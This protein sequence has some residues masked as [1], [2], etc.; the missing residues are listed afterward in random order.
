MSISY[1]RSYENL[2]NDCLQKIMGTTFY[3]G[4]HLLVALKRVREPFWETKTASREPQRA[5]FVGR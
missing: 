2:N 3:M 4:F 1:G 5:M